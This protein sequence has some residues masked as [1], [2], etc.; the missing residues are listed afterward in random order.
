[1]HDASYTISPSQRVF[2]VPFF[3]AALFA[4]A[5]MNFAIGRAAEAYLIKTRTLITGFKF[6]I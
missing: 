5:T 6:N 1:M 4:G 2:F 3:D